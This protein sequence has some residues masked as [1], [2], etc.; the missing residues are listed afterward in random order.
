MSL[1]W[2]RQRLVMDRTPKFAHLNPTGEEVPIFLS[3]PN[4]AIAP[5]NKAYPVDE[6]LW[7]VTGTEVGFFYDVWPIM[8]FPEMCQANPLDALKERVCGQD[9]IACDLTPHDNLAGCN[10]VV[11][12]VEGHYLCNGKP[13]IKTSLQNAEFLPDMYPKCFPTPM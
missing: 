4:V 10:P 13:A 3:G 11:P 5:A 6:A 12:F 8:P 7:V 1:V 2:R 9:A